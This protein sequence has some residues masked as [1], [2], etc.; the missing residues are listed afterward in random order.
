MEVVCTS[1]G[2]SRLLGPSSDCFTAWMMTKSNCLRP[3]EDAGIG[4]SW[5]GVFGN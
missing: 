3:A 5:A 1:E 2:S 4:T